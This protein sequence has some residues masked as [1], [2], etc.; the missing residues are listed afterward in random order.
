ML[1]QATPLLTGS[2]FSFACTNVAQLLSPEEKS[3]GALKKFI[4]WKS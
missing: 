1:A 2:V 3:G 4:F